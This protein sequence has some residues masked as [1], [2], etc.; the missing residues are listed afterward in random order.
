MWDKYSAHFSDLALVF[1][2]ISLVSFAYKFAELKMR[3]WR[4][5]DFLAKQIA[6]RFGWVTIAVSWCWS[7]ESTSYIYRNAI[8]CHTTRSYQQAR[9]FFTFQE[10]C[11][12]LTVP[13]SKWRDTSC[14]RLGITVCKRPRITNFGDQGN[15]GVSPTLPSAAGTVG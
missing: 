10:Q 8:S 11:T 14:T 9:L 5:I 2:V 12:E 3:R 1:F 13:Y 15:P 7:K 6:I 4:E